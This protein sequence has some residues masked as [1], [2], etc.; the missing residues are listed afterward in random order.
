MQPPHHCVLPQLSTAV[1]HSS[2]EQAAPL[3]AQPQAPGT[4]P[5]PQ[6]W[7]GLQVSQ[8][9]VSPQ[10]FT[11]APQATCAQA[12]VLSATQLE[13]GA[14]DAAPDDGENNDEGTPV[15]DE[16]GA[17]AEVAALEA[18][19]PEDG[20]GALVPEDAATDEEDGA[21]TEVA[22]L[23]PA[24][25]DDDG[26]DVPG[27]E[28]DDAADDVARLVAA[29]VVPRS[30]VAAGWEVAVNDDDTRDPAEV[31]AVQ[32]EVTAFPFPG[33]AGSHWPSTHAWPT[34][35]SASDPQLND[36]VASGSQPAACSRPATA[37][38]HPAR[39]MA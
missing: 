11:A 13:D 25:D 37:N 23:A 14:D 4:P 31:T 24:D 5:P 18:D 34:A 2:P 26:R 21:P 15:A 29:E 22:A 9:T 6:V 33:A 32:P 36:A 12:A 35:Q 38:R 10:L 17:A 3:Y 30:L 28:S 19:V 8:V 39:D 27:S 1:P 16:D 20:N 7:G